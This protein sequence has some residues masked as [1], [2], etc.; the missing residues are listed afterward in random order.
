[1]AGH[2]RHNDACESSHDQHGN[3]SA[4]RSN[5]RQLSLVILVIPSL[6]FISH[7]RVRRIRI[8][9]SVAFPAFKVQC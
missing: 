6:A 3:T 5:K 4:L 2:P 9:I 8:I 1:V 7:L